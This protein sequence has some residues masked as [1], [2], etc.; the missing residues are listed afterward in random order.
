RE[1]VPG[2][3]GLSRKGLA[4]W[5]RKNVMTTYH[6]AGTCRMGDDAGA[7]VDPKTL[8][9]RG[10]SNVRVADASV[11]PWTPVSALNAPTMMI[12]LRAAETIAAG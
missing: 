4:R 6:Y 5:A 9:V 2:P 7:V 8:K 3:M 1:L 12:A 11:M 10:L